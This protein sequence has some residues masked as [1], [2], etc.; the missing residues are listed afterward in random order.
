MCV[1]I[2]SFYC[3]Y[4]VVVF[5]I[6]FSSTFSISDRRTVYRSFEYA[7]F[8]KFRTSIA[9][10]SSNHTIRVY[11]KTLA[12]IPWTF[13]FCL[14]K[15]LICVVSVRCFWWHSVVCLYVCVWKI[16]GNNMANIGNAINAHFLTQ[17][18]WLRLN[19]ANK[20]QSE[21]ESHFMNLIQMIQCTW[22]YT[23]I[24]IAT[25]IS[26][27]ALHT[28]HTV[29]VTR[30]YT[31]NSIA[32]ILIKICINVVVSYSHICISALTHSFYVCVHECVH[33]FVCVREKNI[34]SST[35]IM[36]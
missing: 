9:H 8:L 35:R 24:S 30:R 16:D 2:L 20:F 13:Q 1:F 32:F 7:I 11:V 4:L 25:H 33:V 31:Y 6:L 15:C 36:F 3:P 21:S 19:R 5:D 26:H 28:Q 23:C 34:I 27:S 22:K 12:G 29:T 10:S 14:F 17:I 18:S